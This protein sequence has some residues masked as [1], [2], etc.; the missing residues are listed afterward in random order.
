[1]IE[2]PT[3]IRVLLVDDELDFLESTAKALRRRGFDVTTA[4]NGLG[5]LQMCRS[6]KLDVALL[7]VKM[8][9]MD[10]HRLYYEL[11]KE[12]PDMQIIMLTGHGNLQKAFELGKNGLFT[13]LAKPI[14]I[15]DLVKALTDAHNQKAES[16]S[17]DCRKWAES[18]DA[19]S[20]RV[21]LVDD[22]V[23]FLSS[24]EKVLARRGMEVFTAG[25]GRKALDLLAQKRVDVVIV[26]VKMP[27][28]DGMDLLNQIKLDD[29]AIEVVLLTGHGN[30]SLAVR[31]MKQGAFDY[32]TKP[33]ETDEFVRIIRAAH[34]KKKETE[35][36]RRSAQIKKLIEKTPS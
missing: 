22:E 20:V 6:G 30:V 2:N 25:S 32:L 1:M 11:H 27:G 35:V 18:E 21:L 12:V 8:P 23:E 24:M 3:G 19:R 14:E 29:P 26:D 31:G 34:K 33:Q 17:S 36:E 4:S 13:Y 16:S 9:D 7:D 10:G 28:I 5:A 15:D